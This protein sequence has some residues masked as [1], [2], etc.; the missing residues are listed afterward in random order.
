MKAQALQRKPGV[1]EVRRGRRLF[2]VGRC[3]SVSLSAKSD[4]GALFSSRLEAAM[5]R[6]G[7][8]P[9]GIATQ[10]IYLG[11]IANTGSSGPGQR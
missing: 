8:S 10:D 7:G 3:V 9:L 1:S 11:L 5:E 2:S 6:V 4:G